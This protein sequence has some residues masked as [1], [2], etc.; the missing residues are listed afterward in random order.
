M[1]LTSIHLFP[2]DS[3]TSSYQVTIYVIGYYLMLP[4]LC[5]LF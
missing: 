4:A 1:I 5:L 3:S 2:H